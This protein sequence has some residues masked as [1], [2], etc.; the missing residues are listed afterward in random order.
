MAR[1]ET[2]GVGVPD[3][4]VFG[5]QDGAVR[6]GR[7]GVPTQKGANKRNVIKNSVRPP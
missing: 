2:L 6:I 3:K 1:I 4:D 7:S 5:K